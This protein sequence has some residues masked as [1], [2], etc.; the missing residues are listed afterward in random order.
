M[1]PCSRGA[2]SAA[3]IPAATPPSFARTTCIRKARGSTTFH[4]SCTRGCR[5]RLNFNIM[6]SQRGLI[7]LAHSRH[8]LESMSRWA[9]AMRMNGVD[10]RSADAASKSKHLAPDLDMSGT[11][12]YPVLGGLMPARARHRA[13]RRGRMGL[14]ARRIGARASTSS[15]TARSEDSSRRRFA[16]CGVRHHRGRIRAAKV[17]IAAAG[18]SSV[19]AKLAGFAL[20]VTSYA[21]QA[22]VS[23]PLKPILDT[24][25]LS[26][27][28][29]AYVSQSDK[30]EMVI[31]GGLDLFPSYAQRGSFSVMQGI[32]CRRRWSCSPLSAA[33]RCCANGPASSTWCTTR[34]RSSARRR[35]EIS[36]STAA[37]APAAS[38]PFPSGGWTLAHVLAT[39]NDHELAEPFQLDRF[40]TGRLIDEAAAPGSRT[41]DA[42]SI[43]PGA[44][45]VMRPSSSAAATRTSRGPVSLATIATGAKYLFFRDNP[46]GCIASAGAT[47]TAAGNGSIWCATPSR[48]R[49]SR[50]TACTEAT[51][52][53]RA[54]RPP[55]QRRR[56]SIAASRCI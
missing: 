28:T 3:A 36:T 38:R 7:M 49:L 42:A 32:A 23:E 6:L 20:P 24:V 8:D 10:A 56:V 22:M 18:H 34:A 53:T 41:D 55:G 12:R 11:A 25:V 45:R 4:C 33:C 31:G 5:S 29:G 1:W 35:S 39:G 30:G 37:G 43:A 44:A 16:S 2:G 13:P 47:P 40:I 17:G 27:A 14:C 50:C 51:A 46:K 15:R 52:M 26:P 21:L 9:N 48:T 54:Y 19:L